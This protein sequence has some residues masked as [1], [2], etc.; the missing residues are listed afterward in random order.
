MTRLAALLLASSM[1]AGCTP[2]S[3][4]Q[5]A[6]VTSTVTSGPQC[7][8]QVVRD[9][10]ATWPD[11]A[12]V[13][14]VAFGH[15]VPAGF[16]VTPQVRKRD[17]YPRL[18]EDA[19]ADAYPTAVLNVITA[20]VGGEDSTQ[21]RARFQRDALDH[22]PRVVMLDYAL[23]DRALPLDESEGNLRWMINAIRAVG[24]CPVLLTPSWDEDADLSRS[25]DALR[26]QAEMIRRLGQRIQVPVADSLG[27]FQAYTADRAALMAQSNHPNR[28]GH[29][30]V[31]AALLPLFLS[32]DDRQDPQG[33]HR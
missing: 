4:N 23:N 27:Q 32:A 29:E 20:G 18:L 6:A 7:L 17:A 24:A 19:L 28:R 25:D 22:H 3:P 13:N 11:N 15:S 10:K 26:L 33:N 9:L 21:G 1:A 14:I 16:A 12:A 8:E 5:Q 2:P 31:L 30:K